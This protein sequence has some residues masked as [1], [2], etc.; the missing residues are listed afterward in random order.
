MFCSGTKKIKECLLY[1]AAKIYLKIKEIWKP[2]KPKTICMFFAEDKVLVKFRGD[3]NAW[4][5]Y[6]ISKKKERKHSKR[7]K[8]E[9]R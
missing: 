2:P 8:L 6:R 4:H 9:I 7:S 5:I 3:K 1:P